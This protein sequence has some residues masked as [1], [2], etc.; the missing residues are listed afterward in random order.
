MSMRWRLLAT[1]FA[2]CVLAAGAA[3]QQRNGPLTPDDYEGYAKYFAG[4]YALIGQLPNSGA[5][6]CGKVV[7]TAEG[8][9]FKVVRTVAG[10]TTTGQA[11]VDVDPNKNH[12]FVMQFTQGGQ[13]YEATY[14]YLN[15]YDSYPRL[16]GQVAKPGESKD[17]L[18]GHGLEALFP[19]DDPA[20]ATGA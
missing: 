20:C 1:A 15:N 7:I 4:T 2:W 19:A 5:A 14:L 11:F 13:R 17:S 6:Y 16:T 3:A 12:V 8:R 10:E 9:E 18:P